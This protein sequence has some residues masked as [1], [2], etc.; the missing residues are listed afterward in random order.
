MATPIID[1]A[2]FGSAFEPSEISFQSFRVLE[3]DCCVG[4]GLRLGGVLNLLDMPVLTKMSLGIGDEIDGVDDLIEG[5]C[6]ALT[7][8]PRLREVTLDTTCIDEDYHYR[9]GVLGMFL[10]KLPYLEKVTFRGAAIYDS[11]RYLELPQWQLFHFEEAAPKDIVDINA[12]VAFV[13][14]RNPNFKLLMAKCA[15]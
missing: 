11:P 3:I 5:M 8:S 4:D 12:F 13:A 6:S 14:S 10:S 2:Y 1:M 7:Q 9:F 15:G